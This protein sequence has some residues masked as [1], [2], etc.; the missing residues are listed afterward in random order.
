MNNQLT[1]TSASE[2]C[3]PCGLCCDGSLF[4]HAH[5]REGEQDRA[6][7]FGMSVDTL[8]DHARFYLPCLQ[9]KAGCC[10]VYTQQR[11]HICGAFQCKLLNNYINE[12]VDLEIAL[13]YVHTARTLL[14]ELA[15]L[16]P[17]ED[18]SP[19]T[20]KR[21]RMEMAEISAVVDS[22]ERRSQVEFLL[23]A[24]KYEMFILVKFCPQRKVSLKNDE[25][26]EM[27]F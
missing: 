13:G 26:P 3:V 24:A 9:L 19:M 1:P 22:D 20:L 18:P 17:S 2:L 15:R 27:K 4:G 7:G 25:L 23:T 16:S 8:G 12:K 10:F 5:L 6:R 11:P 21:M 14:D